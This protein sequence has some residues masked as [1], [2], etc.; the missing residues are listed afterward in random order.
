MAA[1][2]SGLSNGTE[3]AFRVRA[4]SGDDEGPWS[5][6]I[7]AT[8]YIA[9]DRPAKPL[10]DAGDGSVTVGWS[11][12]DDGGSEITSYD[13]DIALKGKGWKSGP[14]TKTGLTTT[15]IDVTDLTNGTW[16]AFRVRANNAAGSSAWS[17]TAYI[18]PT[19]AQPE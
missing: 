5:D 14:D 4:A 10:V 1:S 18:R 7:H 2:I 16:Y 11:A 15:S 19:A 9:P 3:Y 6:T 8:P 13:I 17:H 12:P